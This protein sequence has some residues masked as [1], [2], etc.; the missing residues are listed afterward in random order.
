M[1][2]S[3]KP[4]S[5]RFWEKTEFGAVKLHPFCIH[6]GT[7]KNVSSSKCKKIG[8]F[9]ITLSKL[10]N[11]CKISEAQIRLIAKELESNDDFCDSWWISY[12]RQK[13]IFIDVVRKYVNV[14]SQLVES[15]L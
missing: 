10:R 2:C 8:H 6:C 11:Y 12:E 14:S 1:P 13:R 7:L 15:L 9:I 4:S 3:H 5:K